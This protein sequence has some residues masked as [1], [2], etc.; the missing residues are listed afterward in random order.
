MEEGDICLEKIDGANNLTD[1]LTKFVD[2]KV[3]QNLNWYSAIKKDVDDRLKIKF[4]V[5]YISLIRVWSP[6]FR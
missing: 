1:M 2:V 3:M 5:D 6:L 4:L